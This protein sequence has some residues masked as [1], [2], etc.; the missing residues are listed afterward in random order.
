MAKFNPIMLK[1]ITA[2]QVINKVET[3]NP[4]NLPPVS[5]LVVYGKKVEHLSRQQLID[6]VYLLVRQLAAMKIRSEGIL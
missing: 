1:T 5:D 2:P 4:D 3:I 6:S